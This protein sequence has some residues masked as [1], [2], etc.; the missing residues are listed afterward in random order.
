MRKVVVIDDE[1]IV[2]EG[3]KS[4]IA[5]E[6]KEYEVIGYAYNGIEGLKEIEEKRP[7]LVITDIRMPGMTGLALIEQAKDKYPNMIFVVLSGYQEFEYARRALTLNVKGYIDKPITLEKIREIIEM[8]EKEIQKKSGFSEYKIQYQTL[9]MKLI[10]MIDED[11]HEGYAEILKEIFKVLG[12]YIENFEEY[13]AELYKFVCLALGIFYEKRKELQEAEHFP[14]FLN[15]ERMSTKEEVEYIITELFTSLFRKIKEKGMKT[16]HR[17]IKEMLEYI[18][19]HFDRDIGLAEIA[20]KVDMNPAYLSNLFKE[21]VGIS[22]V[23]YIT[24]L[25]IE[26]AKQLLTEGGG[27]KVNEV[28]EMV[29]Y[30]NY[31][32]FCDIFKKQTGQ[33][34]NEY[35]KNH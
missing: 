24:K 21:E 22:Y 11:M 5:R 16:I 25:R 12:K 20:D 9:S 14:S 27:K 30:N 8:T 17:T 29:G 10:T 18:N 4:M 33:T 31:R 23:K 15:M 35:K 26:R 7:D 3:I 13:K 2:V 6:T 1:Y 34:P 28:S 32:Y 19:K